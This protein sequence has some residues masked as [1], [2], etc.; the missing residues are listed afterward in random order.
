MYV[1]LVP[2]SVLPTLLGVSGKVY[3]V[4]ALILGLLFLASG[5]RAACAFGVPDPRWG[6]IVGAAISV[7][8]SFDGEFKQKVV[9]KA[10]KTAVDQEKLDVL[11]VVKVE[12]QA[13]ATGQKHIDAMAKTATA[14]GVKFT[15]VQL[16]PSAPSDGISACAGADSGTSVTVSLVLLL[17]PRP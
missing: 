2:V 4:A 10:Y 13:K 8:A 9:A 1:L 3:F 16:W 15:A 6:E 11:N 12:E 7:D 17:L 14:A 5:V